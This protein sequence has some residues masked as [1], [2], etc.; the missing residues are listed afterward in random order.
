MKRLLLTGLLAVSV[1][2]KQNV[3]SVRE[4]LYFLNHNLTKSQ[5]EV[6]KQV[7]NYAKVDNL[8]WT[9]TAIA[10]QESRF[11]EWRHNSSDPSCGVFHQLLPE[12]NHRLG[13]KATTWNNDRRCDDLMN[14]DYAYH[15]FTDTFHIKEQICKANG[16]KTSYS[17]WKCAVKAYNTYGNR[18]YYK[19][20]VNKIKALK[21]WF[22]EKE[23]N[24]DD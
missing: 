21:I 20:I 19:N 10:W 24:L 12:L 3:V 4:D 8:Q 13:L 2:A 14:F 17:I 6:M 7:W 5:F 18:I 15:T 1:F 23:I 11:G 9:A 22:R 16:Y